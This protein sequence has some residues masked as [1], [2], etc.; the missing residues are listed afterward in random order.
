MLKLL[1]EGR[2][3][4]AEWQEQAKAIECGGNQGSGKNDLVHS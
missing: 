3:I 2:L 1:P 4:F